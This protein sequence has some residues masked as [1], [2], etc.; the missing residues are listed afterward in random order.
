M[1]RIINEDLRRIA[2]EPIP[3]RALEGA[4]VLVSGAAGLLPA[5]MA[6]TILFLNREMFGIPAHVVA[7]VRNEARA[8]ARFAR[9]SNAVDLQLVVQDVTEPLR[10]DGPFDYVI[11]A[12]SQAS[13]LFYKTDPVGTFAAN[14]LG[15]HQLLQAAGRGSCRGFLFFSSGDV[16]GHVPSEMELVREEMGGFL[17]PTSPRACYGESKRAGEALCAAWSRQY[18]IP[19]RMVRPGHTYGP[20]MRLDDG[21]VFADFV[22]DI[23]GGGPIVMQSDGLARRCFCYLADATEGFFLALLKGADAEAYNVA[24][25]D[26][27]L[28]IGELADRLAALYA[29]EGMRVERKVRVDSNYIHTAVAGT[30][31]CVDKLKA[32]GWRP[33]T[34][35]EEGF[36]R[37]IAHYRENV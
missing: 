23:V 12:A 13:P 6:E 16:Y 27:D 1:S 19:T 24:N 35:I 29:A 25:P 33:R 10:I 31:P 2:A 15:T 4:R 26:Q 17:D 21:R 8:R 11:H 7:L 34:S 22:R 18:G 37:T 20:G 9:Y 3:W 36:A 32:L 28:A 30:R 5:Y 14:V